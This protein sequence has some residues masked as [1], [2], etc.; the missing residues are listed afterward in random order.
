M[1]RNVNLLKLV[2]FL[3]LV[4]L[5]SACDWQASPHLPSQSD[6]AAEPIQR[7]AATAV[8]G[9]SYPHVVLSS[10]YGVCVPGDFSNGE[11][12]TVSVHDFSSGT[13][14]LV[15]K[16]AKHTVYFSAG[17][18]SV[19]D[20]HLEIISSGPARNT[21]ESGSYNGTGVFRS[22]KLSRDAKSQIWIEYDLEDPTAQQAA[23]S[24]AEAV[25]A[26][27]VAKRQ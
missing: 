23:R 26:C 12:R 5:N 15:N 27:D 14:S 24:L 8:A 11:W 3:I 4:V 9:R 6:Q 16:E 25:F 19:P 7:L 10:I 17:N 20:V 13:L 1:S 18:V 21:I 2:L 22:S